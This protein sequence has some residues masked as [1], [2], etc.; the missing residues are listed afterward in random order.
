MTH[1]VLLGDSTFDNASY[2]E[3]DEPSIV[4]QVSLYLPEGSQASLLAMDGS[5][6]QDMSR[7]LER[8]P[9]DA[10]HLLI[11][12]GGNDTLSYARILLSAAQSSVI[13]MLD[14]VSGMKAEFE[15]NYQQMLTMALSKA[16]GRPV[17]LSTV[18]D[19]CPLSDP[20]WRLLAYTALPMFNDCITR[21]AVREELPLIDLRV[22]CSKETDF[23]EISPI[24]P[25]VSGGAKIAQA[26]ATLI[27]THDFSQP[28]TVIYS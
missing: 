28:R 1:V 16:K 23:S 20:G 22:I 24:E 18:Y 19:K 8:L 27:T 10:S 4:Q 9:T 26:I 14:R 5:S 6:I 2:V 12:I 17:V 15:Q 13:E 11:S 7:Q 3:E 21:Q 25:S